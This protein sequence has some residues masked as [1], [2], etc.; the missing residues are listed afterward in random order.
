[1]ARTGRPKLENAKKNRVT[2]R[3]DDDEFK[4]LKEYADKMNLT[5]T[6]TA[7]KGVEEMLN[8]KP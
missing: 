4:R 2:L 1:M 7:R 5:I 6:E 3:L 8:S